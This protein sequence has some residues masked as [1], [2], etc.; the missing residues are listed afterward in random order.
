MDSEFLSVLFCLCFLDEKKGRYERSY[1]FHT[2]RG[3]VET[4]FLMSMAAMGAILKSAIGFAI[5][6]SVFVLYRLTLFCVKIFS[7]KKTHSTLW[8]FWM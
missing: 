5:V 2:V 4:S 8:A 7:N 3:L 1:D 6:F